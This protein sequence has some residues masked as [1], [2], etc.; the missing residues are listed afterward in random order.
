[1]VSADGSSITPDDPDPSADSTVEE[2]ENGNPVTPTASR[3]PAPQEAVEHEEDAAREGDATE[4]S[5]EADDSGESAAEE[6]AAAAP[7][8]RP[9]K[10]QKV[11]RKKRRISRLVM[12]F[13]PDAVEME[14]RK[15][16]GGLRWTLYTVILLLIATVAWATWARVDRVVRAEGKLISNESFVIK[17]SSTSPIRTLEVKFGDTVKAGQ[18]LVT[19]D[20]SF[21]EADVAKLEGR[22]NSLLAKL[23]R[24]V[25]EQGKAD[26]VIPAG[27]E[28]DE[29]WL[30]ERKAFIDRQ[31]EMDAKM[32][33]FEADHRK[34]VA[35]KNKNAAEVRSLTNRVR[36]RTELLDQVKELRIS[37]SVSR[38]EVIQNQIELDYAESLLITAMNETTEIEADFVKLEKRRDFFLAE[39]QAAVS[40]ELSQ[41]RQQYNEAI[42]ELNKAVWANEM[43]VLTAPDD[44][45]EYKVVEVADFSSVVQSGEPLLRL[46]PKDAELELEV[47]V[48][49]KDVARIREAVAEQTTESGEDLSQNGVP[50]G[51]SVRIKLSAYPY[52]KHGT[53]DGVIKTISED[54]T[55]EG[56]PPMVRSY[57]IVRVK[58]LDTSQLH[59]VPGDQRLLRPGMSAEAEIKIGTRRVIDYF[60]Y[61][62][63][64]SVDSSIRE[65]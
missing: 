18:V 16:A 3:L 41:I 4:P 31:G 54:V 39:R 53:L 48:D 55:E 12:E 62:L 65:P 33:E 46:V 63:F 10:K 38:N 40:V 42:E 56:Q 43:V 27:N 9:T 15:V 11:S 57:Y 34:L 7:A 52:M 37:Q 30:T 32:D 14:H 17:P 64:R 59:D 19:L 6:Q 58:L 29:V 51:T 8:T 1:M 45:P 24:L 25:A 44:Y 2:Q 36:L 13:Q 5:P 26:F 49:A 22:S 60:I 50:S 20:P 47:K 35:Q 21:S 23:Q 61:P 28:T